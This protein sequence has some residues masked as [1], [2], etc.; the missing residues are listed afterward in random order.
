M[1]EV[2]GLPLSLAVCLLEEAGKKDFQIERYIAPRGEHTRG[3][4]RVVRY[5]ERHEKLTV[6]LFPDEVQEEILT[7]ES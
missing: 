6:C 3:T 2:L 5:D 1:T 7:D 4:L